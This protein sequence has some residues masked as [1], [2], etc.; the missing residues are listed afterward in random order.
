MSKIMTEHFPNQQPR[1]ISISRGHSMQNMQI[2]KF[3]SKLGTLV[4][5]GIAPFIYFIIILTLTSFTAA[6]INPSISRFFQLLW[7][8]GNAPSKHQFCTNIQ[9]RWDLTRNLGL[10]VKRLVII[11]RFI[12][13]EFW[14]DYFIS[15]SFRLSLVQDQRCI[16]LESCIHL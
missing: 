13:I 1:G 15:F 6:Y 16:F 8:K 12:R 10:R 7:R 11:K 14:L 5:K 4:S 9:R 2:Q 3:I